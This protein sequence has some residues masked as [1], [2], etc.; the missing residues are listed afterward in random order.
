MG[1]ARRRHLYQKQ[2]GKCFWCGGTCLDVRIGGSFSDI[3]TVDHIVPRSRGGSN[4]WG[5]LVGACYSCNAKRNEIE[6]K[7]DSVRKFYD[8]FKKQP[9]HMFPVDHPEDVRN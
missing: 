5:N 3:F 1:K 8:Y 9:L 7:L 2:K 6:I 4:E